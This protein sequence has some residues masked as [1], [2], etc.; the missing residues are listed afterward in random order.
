MPV[1]EVK[2]L[3][4][5]YQGAVELALKGVN[6][7]I[8]EGEFFGL[9]GPNAAGK[10]T[11]ISIM[12]GLLKI[13]EG[14]V[15]V[16]GTDVAKN[17]ARIKKSI[18][19]VPQ[20]IALYQNL[21]IKENLYYFG[22]MHGLFGYELKRRVAEYLA[23]VE[24]SAH[25]RKIV[26][27][28]S[29]GIKRRANLIAGMIHKPAI[30]FLDEP[31]LGVDAQSRNLI[32]EYLRSLKEEGIT[33]IYTTHYMEEAENLCSRIMIIDNGNAIAGGSPSEL[34]KSN[35]GC[36]DL[37]QVFLKLTGKSLRD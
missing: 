19:L 13:S 23:V 10:T 20:E 33:F 34:I 11:L 26:S 14:E 37:G 17:P 28:C 4:K 27:K 6:L 31:T 2:N 35:P 3:K 32:F 29:G 5:L 21:T 36:N 12:C 7:S 22:Q 30:V 16:A 18:G 9:L 25:A 8:D 24:L 1:I 15:L